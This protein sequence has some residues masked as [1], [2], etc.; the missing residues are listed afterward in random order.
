MSGQSSPSIM[1]TLP[2]FFFL[3]ASKIPSID[4]N[5]L[6]TSGSSCVFPFTYSGTTY[7]SCTTVDYGTTLWCAT[8][9]T[10]SGEVNNYGDCSTSCPVESTVSKAGCP[11]TGSRPCVFPFTYNGVEYS[12]CT[13]V[14]FGSTSWCAVA[15]SSSDVVTSY[16]ICSSSCPRIK[17]WLHQH[18]VQTDGR[19]CKFPFKYGGVTY[20]DCT[21][22]DNSGT[23][24]CSTSV[25][26]ATL[27]VINYGTCNSNCLV[28]PVQL[29]TMEMFIG[30]PHQIQLLERSILTEIVQ[31]D[32]PTE[33]TVSTAGCVTYEKCTNIDFGTIFWCA[34]SVDSSNGVN[35]FGTCSSTCPRE[36]TLASNVCAT[37]RGSKCV[38]PFMY[39]GV[40]YNSCTTVDFGS[41]KWCATSV[42]ASLN[43]LTYGICGSSC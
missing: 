1:R 2:L 17:H 39:N 10:G 41:T 6:T 42:D 33:T 29:W 8:S 31:T 28:D 18:V 22:I 14:D 20:S 12:T 4:A 37:L 36:K 3:L 7:T 19:G 15:V 26:A 38:F 34:T 21:T 11:T 23:P 32:C 5:C 13:T 25:N 30:V 35:S 24:W 40:T 43:Q 27:E 9:V 16:G